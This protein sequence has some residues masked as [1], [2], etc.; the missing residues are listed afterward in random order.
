MSE[1]A[2]IPFVPQSVAQKTVHGAFALGIRQVLVLG[3][4]VLGGIFLARLLTPG[5][6]GI[7]AIVLYFQSFLTS[8]GDAG[9]AAS[10]VRQH[11][12]PGTADYRAIFTI[13]Q[14]L[15]FIITLSMWLAAPLIASKYHLKPQDAWLFRLVALSFFATSFMVVPLVRLER[16]LAFHKVA[17][18]ES[19]QAIV[20]NVLAV[21]F[22]WRG[23]GAYAFVWALLLRS[24]VGTALANWISPWRIGW[25]WDWPLIRTHMAFGLPY[26]GIQITSLLKDSITP[27]FIG[28]LLGTADVGYITWAGMIAAYPMVVLSVLQRLYMPAFARLQHHRDQLI[29]LTE[30]VVWA[31]NAIAA[32]LAILTLVMVVPITTVV[33]GTKWLV[34]LPYFYLFWSANLFVPTA[35]P[36]MGLLNAL[37]KSRTTLLF[38]VIW[39]AGIW[40][41]GAPLILLYGAIGLAIANLIVQFSNFWLYR[42]A[43]RQVPFRLLPVIAPVWAI[44]SASGVLLY[45]L[46]RLHTPQHIVSIGIY[47][48]C[49]LLINGLGMYLLYKGKI[50]AVWASLKG[51]A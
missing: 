40:I 50:N 14:I 5:Q 8:F 31:T 21:Y 18:I 39:M 16:H 26:Q 45:I 36:A 43:Q 11:E 28:L 35:T 23:M 47:G 7:Y 13:Q 33:Y 51:A 30:N 48:T 22:A 12:E 6:F 17:V 15:V 4:R 2:P 27:I 25:H 9:L 10:L 34:A 32:P 37:G 42:A 41:I 44:A 19:V 3:T 1:P 49:G 24:L 38:A 29:A 46:C 20:F